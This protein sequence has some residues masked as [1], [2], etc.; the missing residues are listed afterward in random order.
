[1]LDQEDVREI[2]PWII[3][4]SSISWENEKFIDTSKDGDCQIVAVNSVALDHTG[5]DSEESAAIPAG[6]DHP[7]WQVMAIKSDPFNKPTIKEAL[8]CPDKALWMKAVEIELMNLVNR[9][10]LEFVDPPKDRR[11]ITSKWVLN[12][13]RGEDCGSS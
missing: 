7:A 6:V 12:R 9:D 11:A 3:T 1:M 2:R 10:V 4:D 5:E 13:K 8:A